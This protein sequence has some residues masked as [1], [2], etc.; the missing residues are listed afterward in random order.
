[1]ALEGGEAAG[2]RRLELRREEDS[3]L[4]DDASCDELVRSHVERRVP[5]FNTCSRR[6]ARD[7]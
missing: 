4:C 6:Q 5:H 3:E 1:M 7:M 2:E